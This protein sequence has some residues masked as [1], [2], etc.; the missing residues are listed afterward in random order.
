MKLYLAYGSNLNVDQMKFRCP[1]SYIVGT[2]NMAGKLVFRRGYLTVEPC[3]GSTVP[4][5]VWSISKADELSLDRYEGFPRFYRKETKLVTA[6]GESL[7]A[8]IYIMNDGFPIT[9]P[10]SRYYKTVAEGY[11][12]FGFDE[13]ILARAAARCG[14]EPNLFHF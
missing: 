11:N 14:Y 12:D 6:H 3:A 2:A 5:G 1:D 4:L 13:K 10:S 8:I 9:P 7:E